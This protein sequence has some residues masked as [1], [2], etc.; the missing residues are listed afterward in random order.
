ME[1][2]FARAVSTIKTLFRERGIRSLFCD[3]VLLFGAAFFL[4]SVFVSCSFNEG[5]S[6]NFAKGLTKVDLAT[7]RPHP[8]G[9]PIYMFLGRILFSVTHDELAALT[10]ISI[11]SGSLT[12]IPLYHLT[13]AMY[14]RKTA[15]LTCLVLMLLPGFWLPSE[16]ATTDVVATF[17]LTL[18]ATLL[19]FGSKGNG[20]ATLLSWVVYSFSIGVRPTHLAFVPLW[21]YESLKTKDLKQLFFSICVFIVTC[22]IW[23]MPVIWVTRWDRFLVATRYVFVGTANTD[24]VFA[25]PLGL[26]PLERLAFMVAAVYTFALGGMLPKLSGFK[27]PFSSSSIP[28]FYVAHDILLTGVL[29]CPIIRSRR[30][31][32][33]MFVLLWIVPH[34]VFVYM[35]GSPIHHRYF[36][37]IYPALTLLAVSSV[38][39]L[40][41]GRRFGSLRIDVGKV[42]SFAMTSL[43]IVT[44][45]AHTMPL[46]AKLHTELSPGTQLTRYVKEHYSPGNTTIL[47][48]HEYASFEMYAREFRHYHCRKQILRTLQILK[49]SS[50]SDHTTLVTSTA[51]EY[52]LRHSSVSQLNVSKIEEFYLDPRAEIEDHRLA[53]YLVRTCRL[54]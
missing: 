37:P 30:I 21:L 25:N 33:K 51:Y 24:F 4:Y 43:M 13:R 52:L 27:F 35:F 44:L 45:L 42:V 50:N 31:V 5:D 36:L 54:S 49:A 17:L 39:N 20:T 18:G 9:Y 2:R 28:T 26:D 23:I 3:S 14:D 15:I 1:F 53:L 38:V 29:L 47:V 8:P 12:L 41:I 40:D 11:I 6:F 19:Y 10:W 22:L 16:K 46:A 32:E 7:E 48:F 34:F